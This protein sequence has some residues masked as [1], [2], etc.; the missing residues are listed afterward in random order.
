MLLWPATLGLGATREKMGAYEKWLINIKF[1]VC[2]RE[3]EA[4]Y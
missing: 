4:G 2:S 3:E 1:D